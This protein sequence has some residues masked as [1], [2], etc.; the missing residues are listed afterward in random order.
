MV[1][2]KQ[3]KSSFEFY[4][5]KDVI[6]ITDKIKFGEWFLTDIVRFENGKPVFKIVRR[7][8]DTEQ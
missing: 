4:E 1:A 7:K 2:T 3:V 8:F 6:D 5:S